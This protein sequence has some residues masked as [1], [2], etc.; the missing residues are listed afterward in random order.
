MPNNDVNCFCLISIIKNQVGFN[1]GSMMIQQKLTAV[2]VFFIFLSQGLAANNTNSP[3][4]KANTFLPVNEVYQAD[5]IIEKESVIV[6]WHIKP[7]HFLYQHGFKISWIE[8]GKQIQLS[9]N[10]FNLNDGINKED[11]YFGDVTVYYDSVSL[12]TRITLPIEK[13]LL[14]KA[15]IQGCA[16]A[17]LCYPPYSVFFKITPDGQ[18][19]AIDKAAFTSQLDDT[20]TSVAPLSGLLYVLLFAFLGGL[21]LN[22]MPCVLPVLTLKAFQII[23]QPE[24]GHRQQ[25]LAYL[26]G[27]CLSFITIAAIM[28]SLRSAGN[29]VGWGFQLQ[30]PGFLILLIYLFTLLSLSLTGFIE[31]GTSLMNTGQSLTQSS[32][33]KGS[34]FTGVL[35]VLVASPCTAPFMGSALGF[36]ISQPNWM[37]LLIFLFLGLGMAFP[38]TLISFIPKAAG[39]LPKPGA[40]MESFKIILSFP[41]FLTAIWLLWVLGRQTNIDIVAITLIGCLMMVLAIWLWSSRWWLRFL[42]VLFISSAL[43]LSLAPSIQTRLGENA[44]VTPYSNKQL[45]TLRKQQQAVFVE[46]TADWCI[47]CKTNEITT[48]KTNKVKQ[49]FDKNEIIYMV[50]DWTNENEKITQLLNAYQR[51]G[52]PLYLY[53][54]SSGG[55]PLILPQILTPNLVIDRINQFNKM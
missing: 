25:G 1:I 36:A 54:K 24:H 15:S 19:E 8:N 32:G 43:L 6:Q 22:L 26:A 30:S 12:P 14:I 34:F 28:I 9:A 4:K 45:N 29:Q 49:F 5:L 16:D 17:G 23:N 51:N 10:D 20:A 40:W 21:I 52:V 38:L 53:F 33:A 48:L 41:L 27:I 37:A 55:E 13:P 31:F 3:F 2:L 42:S 11:P 44:K 7:A 50:A 46:V 39:F 18:V 35:A 47:T